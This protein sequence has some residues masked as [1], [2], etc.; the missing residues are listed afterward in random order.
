MIMQFEENLLLPLAW[1]VRGRYYHI[2]L[3]ST[4]GRNFIKIMYI[5]V[6]IVP[7]V[8]KTKLLEYN[9]STFNKL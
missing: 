6:L 3:Q 1:V 5:Y 2:I 7:F 4:G 8:I 9:T